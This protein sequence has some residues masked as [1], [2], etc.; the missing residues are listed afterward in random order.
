V[1]IHPNKIEMGSADIIMRG[2]QGI[3]MITSRGD[4]NSTNAITMDPEN[5]VYIGSGKGIRL[6]SGTVGVTGEAIT[7]KE[8]ANGKAINSATGASVELNDQHLILGYMNTS[9]NAG[10]AIELDK[11]KVVIASGSAT[12]GD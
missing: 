10:N 5:G 12:V 7:Y 2:G 3:K 9:T 6:F 8:S 11:D 1:L 4:N